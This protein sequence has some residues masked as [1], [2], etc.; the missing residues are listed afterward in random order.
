MIPMAR[1]SERDLE[2]AKAFLRRRIDSELSM[3]NDVEYLLGEYA[4]A[5]LELLFRNAPEETVNALVDE[6]I[7]QLIED[8]YILGVDEHEDDR[9]AIMLWMNGERGGNTMEGRVEKRVHSF[10]V[11]V[12]AVFLASRLLG[13]AKGVGALAATI[14]TNLK[15]PWD[16]PILKE[17]REKLAKG[18]LSG[19][20][21]EF[22]APHFG[23]GVEVSSMGALQTI[24]GYAVADAWM[25]WAYEDARKNGA[26]GYYVL[27]GS[28]YPCDICDSHTGT[29][30]YITD[31][32]H[33]PQF[34][35]NCCCFVVY[36]YLERV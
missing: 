36:S 35:P 11:E 21:S 20:I 2:A 12:A 17:V 18:E 34:H 23:K 13:S 4:E 29:F 24:L 7:Q 32:S 9:S 10:V 6:L 1:Y 31:D 26:I 19:D 33:Q 27:R 22:E 25:H 14:R 15:N 30:Y 5:L 8:C 16:N 3:S 28:S